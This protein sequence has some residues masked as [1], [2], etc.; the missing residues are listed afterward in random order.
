M[1]YLSFPI[2]ILDYRWKGAGYYRFMEPAGYM[3]PGTGPGRDFCG[4][5]A[6]VWI[7]GTQPTQQGTKSV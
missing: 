4:T 3:M 6:A 7:P 1:L 2:K 5:W